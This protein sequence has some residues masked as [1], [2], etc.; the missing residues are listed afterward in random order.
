MW[1]QNDGLRVP[2]LTGAPI[3]SACEVKSSKSTTANNNT[4]W[5]WNVQ[6]KTTRPILERKLVFFSS[7]RDQKRN[8]IPD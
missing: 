7:A 8:F 4:T 1:K 3:N 2:T 5:S 6:M